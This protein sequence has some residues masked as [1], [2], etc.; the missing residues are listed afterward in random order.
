MLQ[1]NTGPT[2]T[3]FNLTNL[4]HACGIPFKCIWHSLTSNPFTN[5]DILKHIFCIQYGNYT[6]QQNTD[7]SCS[8]CMPAYPMLMF[9]P[10]PHTSETC[11]D[12]LWF[13]LHYAPFYQVLI[14][15]LN[16]TDCLISLS[17]TVDVGWANLSCFWHVR[18]PVF[19]YKAMQLL[20]SNERYTGQITQHCTTCHLCKWLPNT[21]HMQH[22]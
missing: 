7:H 15:P 5:L 21:H 10:N 22:F 20:G 2:V 9:L 3:N 16:F 6:T 1:W 17:G 8:F 11:A 4:T 18:C 14:S 19:T 12:Y 13:L